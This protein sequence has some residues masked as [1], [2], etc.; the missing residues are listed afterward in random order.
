MTVEFIK[1]ENGFLLLRTDDPDLP[2]LEK[3]KPGK[4]EIIKI[5]EKRTTRANA[6][7]WAL[8]K[9]ISKAVGITKNEVYRNAIKEMNVY[10]DVGGLTEADAATLM[11]AWQ[12]NGQGW[13][14]E[15]VDY[16]PDG[17][18]V[19]VRFYYGSSTYNAKQM[20]RLID[21]LIE[22]ARSVGVQTPSDEYLHHLMED[23]ERSTR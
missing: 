21:L 4:Y 5:I 15:K 10:K 22:D 11:T 3:F 13:V 6:Y 2:F 16:E 9:D 23:Y 18:H 14:A 12:M 8:C 20:Q 7:M 19:M 1:Y 17:E